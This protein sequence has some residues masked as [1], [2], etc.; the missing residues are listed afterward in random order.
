MSLETRTIGLGIAL[1]AFFAVATMAA[2]QN[3][4]QSGGSHGSGTWSGLLD[5]HWFFHYTAYEYT[6]GS[7]RTQQKV[8]E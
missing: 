5:G 4:P 6:L 7:L 3:L 2:E 1:A 8:R